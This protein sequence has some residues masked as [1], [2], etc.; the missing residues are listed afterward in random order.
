MYDHW[1]PYFAYGQ[2]QHALC[3]EHLLRELKF[4][5]EEDGQEVWAR[6]MSAI[7][8]CPSIGGGGSARESL[9]GERQFAGPGERYRN[10]GAA[11]TLPAP[12]PGLRP[13]P[14]RAKQGA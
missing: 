9:T 3:N 4:L 5:W 6:E 14:I 2:C 1:K 13:G 11:R 10:G 7:C 8:S 12:A